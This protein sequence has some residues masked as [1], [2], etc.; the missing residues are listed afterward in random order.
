MGFKTNIRTVRDTVTTKG[1]WRRRKDGSISDEELQARWDTIFKKT[2]EEEKPK[3][4]ESKKQ[5]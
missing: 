5:D 2:P 4:E 3:V 1:S